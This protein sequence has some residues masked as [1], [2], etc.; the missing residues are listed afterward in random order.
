MKEEQASLLLAML[1]TG[2]GRLRNAIQNILDFDYDYERNILNRWKSSLKGGDCRK[3]HDS[4]RPPP[5][6][7]ATWDCSGSGSSKTCHL[8]CDGSRN[9]QSTT[10]DRKNSAG[11]VNSVAQRLFYVILFFSQM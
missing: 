2:R 3:C 9:G 6:V 10:C 4:M 1:A 7:G 5:A 8:L 11:W